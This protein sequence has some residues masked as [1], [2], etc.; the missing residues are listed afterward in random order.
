MTRLRAA[1]EFVVDW[2]VILVA[3]AVVTLGLYAVV[4]TIGDAS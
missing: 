4:L 1:V 2:T 3:L